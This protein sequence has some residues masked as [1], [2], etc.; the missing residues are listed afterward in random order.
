M[1]SKIIIQ[2]PDEDTFVDLSIFLLLFRGL[3]KHDLSNMI[4]HSIQRPQIRFISKFYTSRSKN[5]YFKA[6]CYF[7]FT[8]PVWIPDSD[9]MI[10]LNDD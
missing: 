5:E 4:L 8:H 6:Y 7:Y 9:Q 3:L 2:K 10:I 1:E